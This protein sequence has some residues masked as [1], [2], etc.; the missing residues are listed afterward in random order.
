MHIKRTDKNPLLRG[1]GTPVHREKPASLP[2]TR[3]E[4]GTT[5][6][7]P[8]E[9]GCGKVGTLKK[10]KRARREGTLTSIQGSVTAWKGSQFYFL[11]GAKLPGPNLARRVFFV[12]L[13]FRV[14]AMLQARIETEVY[15]R[16]PLFPSLPPSL[17]LLRIFSFFL[18]SI[19]FHFFL[20]LI[21]WTP[22]TGPAKWALRSLL[23]PPPLYPCNPPPH[24][25]Y[26]Y[27]HRSWQCTT[28]PGRPFLVCSVG[29]PKTTAAA[30]ENR[31][32]TPYNHIVVLPL[33]SSSTTIVALSLFHS[34]SLF[35]HP[36]TKRN[37]TWD[38]R[39][40]IK[41]AFLNSVTVEATT[42][43]RT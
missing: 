1:S 32:S 24:L 7:V 40:S 35:P 28:S 43:L 39:S 19:F 14:S 38:V 36:R 30:A 41:A 23:I 34:F 3:T 17:F 33:G 2:G 25:P 29:S 5:G 13:G 37:Y 42:V 6:V 20:T 22:G 8:K 15:R 9:E 16:G 27:Q 18:L 21:L 12:W 4:T 10:K 11:W 31:C 26:Y